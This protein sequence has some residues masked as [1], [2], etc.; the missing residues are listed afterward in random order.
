MDLEK[1][2]L[3]GKE[4][5]TRLTNTFQE[6]LTE[7]NFADVTLVSDDHIKIAAHKLILSAS[8]PVLRSMLMDNPHPHPII[9]M[10]GVTFQDLQSLLQFMYIGQVRIYQDRF[11]EF[12]ALL[13][14]LQVT[15]EYEVEE[16]SESTTSEGKT[17]DK[18][19]D[20]KEEYAVREQNVSESTFTGEEPFIYKNSDDIETRVCIE[21]NKDIIHKIKNEDKPLSNKKG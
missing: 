15:G 2:C 19:L 1:Y 20:L 5:P 10:R 13:K 16:V 4:F 14:D 17:I 9:F 12:I 3:S 7:K 21:S 11:Q 18:H 6:L 8:S